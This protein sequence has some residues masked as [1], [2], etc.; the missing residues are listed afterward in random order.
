[1]LFFCWDN[2]IV[3]VNSDGVIFVGGD[4]VEEFGVKGLEFSEFLLKMSGFA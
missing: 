2:L 4:R 1:M 3:K